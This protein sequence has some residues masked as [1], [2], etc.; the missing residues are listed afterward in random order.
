MNSVYKYLKTCKFNIKS[1]I[2]CKLLHNYTLYWLSSGEISYFSESGRNASK[3]GHKYK[4]RAKIVIYLNGVFLLR[5]TAKIQPFCYYKFF[6]QLRSFKQGT[7][8]KWV[9]YNGIFLEAVEV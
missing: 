9:A 2:L 6:N 8:P 5:P 1:S 4:L 3:F 7:G